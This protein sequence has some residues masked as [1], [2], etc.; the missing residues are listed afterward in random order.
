MIDFDPEDQ[1]QDVVGDD[2]SSSASDEDPAEAREHYVDVGY[3]AS[4]PRISC[5]TKIDQE[6]RTSQI[7]WHCSRAS[8]QRLQYKP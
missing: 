6:K 2:A 5:L 1:D 8:I 7:Q 3:A 4:Q